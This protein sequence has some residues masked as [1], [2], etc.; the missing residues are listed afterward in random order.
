MWTRCI[1]T[2]FRSGC[3]GRLVAD[4]RIGPEATKTYIAR[5]VKSLTEYELDPMKL[6]QVRRELGAELEKATVGARRGL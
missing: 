1:T 4:R 3:E 5:L 2:G 6:E